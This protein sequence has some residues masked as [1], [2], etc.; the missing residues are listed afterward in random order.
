MQG[1]ERSI[2]Q[3]KYNR[4]GDLLFSSSKDKTPNVWFSLNGERL[5]TYNG[6]NGAVWCIDIDWQTINFMSGSADATCKIWDARTAQVKHNFQCANA[7]RSCGF[8]YSGNLVMY[9][10]DS[11]LKENCYIIVRDL[12]TPDEAIKQFDITG[13]KY[14]KIT[15]SIWGT[16][17]DT[18]ITGHE[19]G[20]VM[21]WD[22]RK[23]TNESLMRI[24]PHNKQV[25]DLQ[26]DRE[27]TCF[28]SASKDFTAKVVWFSLF[29]GLNKKV[30]SEFFF[31]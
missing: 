21:M 18:I 10:T 1:H 17:E 19:G 22:M 29:L 16:L 6:H 7:V 8:S 2:T 12:R 27:S 11:T 20:E 25:M 15:S 9:T 30:L 3:I 5:G 14:A 28:I 24:R 4:E 26:K 23:K 13:M 31:V